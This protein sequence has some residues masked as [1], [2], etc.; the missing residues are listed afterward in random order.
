MG[1][2]QDRSC[3]E[4]VSYVFG[5]LLLMTVCSLISGSSLSVGLKVFGSIIALV[6]IAAASTAIMVKIRFKS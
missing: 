2:Y 6:V 3:W 1:G 5:L 4:I